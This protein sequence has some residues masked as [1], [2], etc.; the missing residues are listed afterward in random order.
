MDPRPE[1]RPS[2]QA[3]SEGTFLTLLVSDLVDSTGVVERLGDRRAAGLLR[4]H[5][6]IAR[7]LL[8]RHAGREIDKTDGFLLV[9]D[10]PVQAVHYALAYHDALREL[11]RAEGVELE[12]RV[13]VHFG[14]VF[15]HENPVEDVRKGAKPLEVE[16]L[17][18]PVA[19]RLMSLARGGQTL[20][21]STAHELARRAAR[22]DPELD[23]DG[24]GWTGH[25]RYRLQG[26]EN[27]VE[28]FEVGRRGLAPFTR[29]A[30]VAKA[31]HEAAGTRRR[32]LHWGV[33]AAG[34][35]LV[36]ALGFVGVKL[37]GPSQEALALTPDDWIV[38]GD[39]RNLTGDPLLDESL[40]LAFRVGLEQSRFARVVPDHRMRRVLERMRRGPDTRV[41]RAVGLEICRR[42]G[43]KALVTGS[44]SEIGGSFAVSAEVIEP[45][46]G[47]SVVT[48]T[49]T[50]RRREDLVE[51]LG[52]L[53]RD[54]RQELGESLS[55]IQESG[56]PLEEVTTSDLE[57]LKAYSVGL[58][59]AAEGD[60]LTALDLLTRATALD[61]E[62]A[63]AHAKLGTIYYSRLGDQEEAVA[64]WDRA[65][66][67]T[68]RLSEREELYVQ[69]SKAWLAEPP[70]KVRAWKLMTSLYPDEAVGH[71]NLGLVYW[72]YYSRFRDALDSLELATEGRDPW[73]VIAYHNTGYCQLGLGRVEEAVRTF[74]SAW[75]LEPNPERGGLAD[76]Y[77]AAGRRSDAE[78]FIQEMADNR[79]PLVALEA[80]L[81]RAD[82]ELDRGRLE[83]ALPATRE[84]EEL[85]REIGLPKG[86]ERARAAS[87]A[88]LEGLGRYGEL[89]A[90]LGTH[91]DELVEALSGEGALIDRPV[92]HLALLGKV[93]ARNGWTPEAQHA[94]EAV[95]PLVRSTDIDLW[96]AHLETLAA[97][98]ALTRGDAPGAVERAR[99]ALQLVDLFQAHETLARAH[100]AAGD[101]QAARAEARWLVEHRGHALA[102]W[103]DEFYGRQFNLLDWLRARYRLGELAEAMGEPDQA[104]A[105][106][107]EL[108]NHWSAAEQGLPLR[109][110]A[111][112]RL[113][114]L[115]PAAAGGR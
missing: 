56:P 8:E 112:A 29:P 115:A 20:L 104:R 38:V 47:A 76:A 92:P 98:L 72:W 18:K 11:S 37:F 4:R 15:L 43:A 67:L 110:A 50:T 3:R 83:T 102:E 71:N 62:F 34:A 85:A 74:E 19:A 55:A 70:E 84:A 89:R 1:P 54:L 45:R 108:L 69:G 68:D 96:E 13:G 94:F 57:A 33:A 59:K 48:R 63:T 2:G 10:R 100:R 99:R 30:D 12:A 32:A 66:A 14:E 7:E 52:T 28:V 88:L 64:H 113:A 78:R 90:D 61:P 49:E 51:T 105:R 39:L 58:R 16:G 26:V 80:R 73:I 41:D 111:A 93:A 77:L 22:A 6:R 107:R 24:I 103:L 44:I 9:F 97:E 35:A 95:E 17:A 75:D 101:L 82:L 53:T 31:R 60:L 27:A 65:L 81:R 106:Y 79:T 40:G 46:S 23:S 114:E 42:E 87:L 25:G 36:L 86:R 21:T 5:D 91:M 109:D